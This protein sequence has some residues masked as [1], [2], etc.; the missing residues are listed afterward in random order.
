MANAI[1][2]KRSPFEL[3]TSYLNMLG[4]V[5]DQHGDYHSAE[6]TFSVS[7]DNPETADFT[8]FVDCPSCGDDD[9]MIVLK[10]SKEFEG[11]LVSFYEHTCTGCTRRQYSV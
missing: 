5:E 9:D 11:R 1:L 3:L 6:G 8:H 2:T 7:L 10:F 4:G